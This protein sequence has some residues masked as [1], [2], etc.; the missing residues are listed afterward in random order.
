MN[1][2][3]FMDILQK[4]DKWESSMKVLDAIRT[5]KIIGYV[6]PSSAVA[7]STLAPSLSSLLP[8]QSQP[9]ASLDNKKHVPPAFLM[10]NYGP[11][12]D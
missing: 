10:G 7:S 1:Q 5:E 8:P 2:V 3:T 9:L 11:F 4:R 12:F 6:P